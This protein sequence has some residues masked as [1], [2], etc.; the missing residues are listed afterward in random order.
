MW[1]ACSADCGQG[2]SSR[3]VSCSL[4]TGIACGLE[5]RPA[6]EMQCEEDVGCG[7]ELEVVFL[8]TGCILC[9][10]CLVEGEGVLRLLP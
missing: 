10:A 7:M 9:C 5:E 4:G 3:H 1:S 8:V 2:T 6:E